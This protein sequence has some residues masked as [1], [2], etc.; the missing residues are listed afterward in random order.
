MTSVLVNDSSTKEFKMERG[1]R[2]G[3]PLS[4]FHFVLVAEGLNVLMY[5]LVET[6]LFTAYCLGDHTTTTIS[7]L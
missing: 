2:Q 7:N 1:F 3:D 4:P 6:S 5:A